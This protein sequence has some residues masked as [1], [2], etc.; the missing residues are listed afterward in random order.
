MRKS[1][2]FTSIKSLVPIAWDADADVNSEWKVSAVMKKNV[3]MKYG[4]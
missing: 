4:T 1:I 2:S 3:R